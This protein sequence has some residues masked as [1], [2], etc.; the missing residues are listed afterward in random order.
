MGRAPRAAKAIDERRRH[1]R[2]GRQDGGQ[3]A[4]L[5][6]GLRVA[7]RPDQRERHEAGRQREP[8]DRRTDDVDAALPAR[9]LPAR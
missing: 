9:C 8:E 3:L 2:D 1:E 4:R 5:D 7:F 6:G